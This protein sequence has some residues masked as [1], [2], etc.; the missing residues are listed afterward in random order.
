MR[1]RCQSD[2]LGRRTAPTGASGGTPMRDG[3]SWKMNEPMVAPLEITVTDDFMVRI[4]GE[5]DLY[6]SQML[7]ETV[8]DAIG[9]TAPAVV[10]IDLSECTLLDCAGL[11][12]LV[13]CLKGIAGRGASA[14]ITN[15]SVPSRRAIVLAGLGS[16][17][18]H[19]ERPRARNVSANGN[20]SHETGLRT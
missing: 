8:G 13:H 2:G 12:S 9:D 15:T 14:T 20:D 3:G 10:T 4:S 19:D 6:S 11:S 5:L 7:P 17:L 1:P 18:P 16:L